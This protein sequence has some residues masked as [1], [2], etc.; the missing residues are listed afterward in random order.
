M[1]I[2]RSKA[3]FQY[4]LSVLLI[5]VVV[6]VCSPPKV[7]TAKGSGNP[8]KGHQLRFI[9]GRSSSFILKTSRLYKP[10]AAITVD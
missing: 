6:F 4:G 9:C 7:A 8:I 10:S 5:T 2:H 3:S 1:H